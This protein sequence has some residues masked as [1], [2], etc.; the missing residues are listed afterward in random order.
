MR[1]IAFSVLASRIAN[2]MGWNPRLLD[3]K[4]FDALRDAVAEALSEIWGATWWRDLKRI[5]RRQYRATYD[6]ILEY[7]AGDEVYFPATDGYFVAIRTTTGNP[8]QT[9]SGDSWV[10]NAGYW[11]PAATANAAT[12]YDAAVA[13]VPGDQVRYEG[14]VYQCH[15]ASTGAVPSDTAHW[16]PVPDFLPYVAWYQSGNEG[17]GRVRRVWSDDPRTRRNA[18]RLEFEGTDLGVQL[19]DITVT[20]PWIEFQPPHHKL[21]GDVWDPAASYT[22]ETS[23]PS[24]AFTPVISRGDYPSYATVGE[25]RSKIITADRVD[26]LADGNG[27][28]ATF[29]RDATYVDDGFDVTGFADAVGTAFRRIQRT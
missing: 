28:P 20:R 17:I 23:E 11:A 6:A 18:R 3:A 24:T 25:A 15:T 22:P 27:D 8:P 14:E 4:Q 19:L 13:Y 7:V 1:S 26:V 9:A 10:L 12:D 2:L 29:W 21:T 16:G 5:Q